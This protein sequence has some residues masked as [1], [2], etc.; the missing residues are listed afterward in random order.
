MSQVSEYVEGLKYFIPE[1]PE[2]WLSGEASFNFGNEA[3]IYGVFSDFGT[4]VIERLEAGKL[5]NGARLFSFIESVV[6]A[7]GDPANAAC[8]CFLENILNRT[9][10]TI[11]P[12]SYVPY[13]GPKSREFCRGWDEFTGVKTSGL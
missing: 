5:S 8:T 6:A 2:Y 3:T 12:K 1:F 9:P 13:L 7:G 4:L 11:E 10:S